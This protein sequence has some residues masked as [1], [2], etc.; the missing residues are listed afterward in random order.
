MQTGPK[1]TEPPPLLGLPLAPARPSQGT[2]VTS[3]LLQDGPPYP[4]CQG[5]MGSPQEGHGVGRARCLAA[6]RVGG[7]SP[8]GTSK[9]VSQ[10]VLG[11]SD[12]GSMLVTMWVLP[13]TARPAL[14]PPKDAQPP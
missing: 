13:A 5:P 9:E 4:G 8:P 7:Q 2:R 10:S 12:S 1:S 6:L 11:F 3:Q 14:R